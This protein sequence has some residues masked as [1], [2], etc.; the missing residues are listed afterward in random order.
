MRILFASLIP[1]YWGGSEELW[2]R[3]A[4]N[5]AANGHQVSAVFALR[6]E[7]PAVDQLAAAGV[8]FHHGTP[9]PRR[10]WWRWFAPARERPLPEVIRTAL[11]RERPELVVFSQCAVANG[12]AAIR[13][14]QAAGVPCAIIN[15]LVEPLNHSSAL[16]RD[17]DQAYA[18]ARCLW[19]VSPENLETV[20][21]WLG[22]ELPN[23]TSIPNAYACP[24]QSELPALSPDGP[25][26]LA[27]VARLEPEQKG[28][29]TII[30]IMARPE[31]REREVTVTFFGNGPAQTALAALSQTLPP[32]RVRF[33][34]HASGEE[35]WRS[36]H[37]LVMPSRYEGQ[38]L[39]MIEAMLHGRPV[40]ATPVGGTRGL[41][42]DGETGFLA[43]GT[44]AA[45]F[46]AALERAW[47]SRRQW[48]ALGSSAARRARAHVA[49]D[50]GAAM[51]GLILAA[52]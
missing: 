16:R 26:R 3:A 39:A 33:G 27:L 11:R 9:A 1:S 17:I 38:S 30:E 7:A 22:R 46:G 36:H 29:D 44:D 50:P 41:V 15:Q 51:A 42:R 32:N 4:S 18:A 21:A 45:A 25:V 14:C 35:I 49:P 34:G 8:R 6:R 37:A 10:W 2:S 48:P 47:Q 40:I 13:Q 28:Q 43:T 52:A 23:A 5:L 31:W 20:A 24:Y 19:F 12:I